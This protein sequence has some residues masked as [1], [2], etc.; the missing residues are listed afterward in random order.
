MKTGAAADKAQKVAGEVTQEFV[1]NMFKELD[2]QR[3]ANRVQTR[4]MSAA[5]KGQDNKK[6]ETTQ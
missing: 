2:E 4:R 5:K 3:I 1:D 6:T